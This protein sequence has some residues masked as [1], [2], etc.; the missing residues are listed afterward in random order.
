MRLVNSSDDLYHKDETAV[1]KQI[2]YCSEI[3]QSD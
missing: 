3:H 1:K 2:I